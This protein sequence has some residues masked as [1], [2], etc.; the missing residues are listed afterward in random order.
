MKR[1]ASE[2]AQLDETMLATLVSDPDAIEMLRD[3]IAK[4]TKS[5]LQVIAPRWAARGNN[6]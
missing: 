1:D 6:R 2:P 5:N 3:Y 4:K